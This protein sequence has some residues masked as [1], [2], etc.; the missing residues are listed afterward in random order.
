M[1]RSTGRST[2]TPGGRPT[3]S[4][5]CHGNEGDNDQAASSSIWPRPEGSGESRHQAKRI[6]SD[7]AWHPEA[8]SSAPCTVTNAS[9]C[10]FTNSIPTRG[11][12]KLFAGQPQDLDTIDMTW[13]PDGNS[14]FCGWRQMTMCL[15]S[16]SSAESVSASFLCLCRVSVALSFLIL[17]CKHHRVTTKHRKNDALGIRSSQKNGF[18][19]VN[20][21]FHEAAWR[22]L[23]PFIDNVA[24]A[25]VGCRDYAHDFSLSF[26][27][28]NSNRGRSHETLSAAHWSSQCLSFVCPRWP[29]DEPQVA[30]KKAVARSLPANRSR[31]EGEAQEPKVRRRSRSRTWAPLWRPR[32]KARSQG[33]E[34]SDRCSSAAVDS[35]FTQQFADAH[36]GTELHS[37]GMHWLLISSADQGGR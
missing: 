6:H 34:R 8:A 36:H 33:G 13:T 23:I 1:T 17:I 37:S 19:V 9:E 11:P 18:I 35:S 25:C 24:R 16:A 3:A 15:S 5:V 22:E 20:H 26:R 14:S 21:C 30:I 12:T 32:G 4:P 31:Q 27:Q 10:S 28:G 29:A 2:S 7:F